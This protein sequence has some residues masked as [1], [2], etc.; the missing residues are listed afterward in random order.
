MRIFSI[1]IFYA[2]HLFSVP[3]VGC[4]FGYSEAPFDNTISNI[5][6][7]K[8][9]LRLICDVEKEELAVV[10]ELRSKEREVQPNGDNK[11][12]EE[13]DGQLEECNQVIDSN[14]IREC[15]AESPKIKSPNIESPNIKS[16]KRED[17]GE[18]VQKEQRLVD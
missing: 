15:E 8:A 4:F 3:V 11:P 9:K 10:E 13:L 1:L 12:H 17:I 7:L 6:R 5:E 14:S 2:L 18:V 16:S